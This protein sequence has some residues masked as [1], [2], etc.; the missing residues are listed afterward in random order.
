MKIIVSTHQGQLYNEDVDYIV[1]H[2]QDGEFAIM[3]NCLPI[4]SV[5][6]LGYIKL[7]RDMTAPFNA[8]NFSLNK[9]EKFDSTDF[10]TWCWFPKFTIIN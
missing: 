2:N 4:I 3:K 5:I 8:F 9:S 7:V 1:V 6:S 10:V